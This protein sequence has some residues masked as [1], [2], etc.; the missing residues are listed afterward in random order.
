MS[1]AFEL[2]EPVDTLHERLADLADEAPTGGAPPAELWAR[3][4]RAYRLRVAAV[5]ATVLVGAVGTGIGVGLAHGDD[6]RLVTEPAGTV[7]ISLPIEYP[8]G[9]DLPDLGDAPGPL[10]AIWLG[11]TGGGAPEVIGLVAATGTFGTLPIDVSDTQY[12]Y[13]AANPGVALSP[14]GRRIAYLT[15]PTDEL[16]VH[17]L[18]SGENDLPKIENKLLGAYGWIDATH[19]VG[20]AGSRS[21][22]RDTDGWV[23]EPGK[24][25]KLVNLA[26]YPGQPYLGYGWPYAGKDLMVLTQGPKLCS[27]PRLQEVSTEDPNP[28]MFDVPVL[29]DILGVVGS[30]VLLGHWNSEQLAGDSNDPKYADGTVVALDIAGADRPYLNPA[31]R[32]PGADHAFEDPALRRVVVTAGSPHRIAFATDLIAEALESDGGGS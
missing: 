11:P 29:C 16:V 23:W 12:A 21:G 4:K 32:N 7:D 8:V 28:T 19:L 27:S 3:G 6:D 1:E 2:E 17:D 10:A 30:Q 5:A 18:V 20:P 9:Q 25:P 26:A 14:D 15:T 31:L 24:E 22:I 13:T